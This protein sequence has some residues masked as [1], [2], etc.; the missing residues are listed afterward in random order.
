MVWNEKIALFGITLFACAKW[1][2]EMTSYYS[3]WPKHITRSKS[4]NLEFDESQ[5]GMSPLVQAQAAVSRAAP[6]LL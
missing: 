5:I 6:S 3:C 1:N 2:D 4:W